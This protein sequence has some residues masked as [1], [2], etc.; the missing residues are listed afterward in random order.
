M[1]IYSLILILFFISLHTKAQQ[2]Q[3]INY[4]ENKDAGHYLSTR[5]IKLYYEVYGQGS[6]LLF[7]HGNGGSLA[8]FSNNIPYFSQHYK[9]IAVDSRAHGKSIDNNDSLS[10]EMMADDFNALLDNG[11]FF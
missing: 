6:P 7:I 4:G 5:G 1:R 9:V 3:K 8:N 11:S 10:F 2:T